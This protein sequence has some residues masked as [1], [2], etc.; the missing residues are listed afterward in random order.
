WH[1]TSLLPA[2]AL[3][4]RL[5]GDAAREIGARDEAI[6]A[7]AQA[8]ELDPALHDVL[9]LLAAPCAEAGKNEDAARTYVSALE[10]FA[11][12][13]KLWAGYG[14][15]LQRL[16]R[17]EDSAKAYAKA[18]E[19]GGDS[20]SGLLIDLGLGYVRSKQWAQALDALEKCAA[21]APRDA[22][23]RE[24][25]A[26]T[27]R[28]LGDVPGAEREYAKAVELDPSRGNALKS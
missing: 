1:A 22:N 3:A 20:S 16:G 15:V 25:L 5:L 8:L 7:C 9:P 14:Q 6:G 27:R 18:V 11:E 19:L 10:R 2:D 23:V 21:L 17:H 12:D 24:S 13:S 26:L 4:W 28:M